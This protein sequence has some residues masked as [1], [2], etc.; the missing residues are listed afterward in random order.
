[1]SPEEELTLAQH[2]FVGR[3][4]FGWC[5]VEGCGLQGRAD[6]HLIEADLPKGWIRCHRCGAWIEPGTPTRIDPDP[7]IGV[8]HGDRAECDR[9]IEIGEAMGVY[10]PE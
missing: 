1:M 7:R 10:D 8:A 9:L 4:P 5:T 2:R 3:R 6:V